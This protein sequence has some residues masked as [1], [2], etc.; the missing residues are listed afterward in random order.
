MRSEIAFFREVFEVFNQ[1]CLWVTNQRLAAFRYCESSFPIPEEL[2]LILRV[3]CSSLNIWSC[4]FPDELR[5]AGNGI[6][7]GLPDHIYE[8]AQPILIKL[9][10]TMYGAALLAV[11]SQEAFDSAD[12][13]S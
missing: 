1:V 9:P 4:A 13:L 6:H 12:R 2:M 5:T 3:R 10:L 8:S 7:E 11:S